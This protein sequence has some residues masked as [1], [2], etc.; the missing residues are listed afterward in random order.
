MGTG[1]R[2]DRALLEHVMSVV[3]RCGMTIEETLRLPNRDAVSRD[4]PG[5]LAAR[6]RQLLEHTFPDGLYSHQTEAIDGALDGRDICLATNTASGKTLVF[7]TAA[8]NLLLQDRSARVL[9]L[10][11]ARALIQDQRQKWER[12]LVPLGLTFSHIDGG[13]PIADR[14][15]RL[16]SQVVLMTPDVLHAWMMSHLGDDQVRHFLAHVRLLILDELHVYEG[17]F[18]SNMAYLLRRL[19]AVTRRPQIICS[20]ATL[21]KPESFVAQLTGRAVTTLGPSDDGSP[22]PPKDIVLL[23]GRADTFEATVDL[24]CSLG[25][26]HL[27]RFLAFADSRKAVERIVAATYRDHRGVARP[28][29]LEDTGEGLEPQGDEDV[30]DEEIGLPTPTL[31]GQAILPYRAGYETDDRLAVQQA[32]TNGDLVGV[33]STSALELG[34]DI[35]DIDVVVLLDVPPTLKSFWQRLGRAGRRNPAVCLIFD[36]RGRLPKLG[37]ELAAYLE[38]PIEPN[39]LYLDNRYIQYANV[40]CAAAEI[41]GDHIPEPFNSLPSSFIEFLQNEIHPQELV[42]ADLYQL[43]QRGQND[44]HHEFALRGAVEQSFRIRD[45]AGKLGDVTLAQA[46]RE[47]YPGAVYLYMARPHRIRG[48]QYRTG[49][50][51]AAY[52]PMYTTRPITQ[53]TVFPR[54]DGGILTYLKSASGFAIEA[55]MQVS[56]RVTGFTEQRG[57]TR[58]M[59]L[60]GPGSPYSQR[61]LYRFFETTGVCWLLGQGSQLSEVALDAILQTFAAEFGIQERDLGYGYFHSNVRPDGPGPVRGTCIYDTTQGS[62]RLTQLLAGHFKEVVRSTLTAVRDGALGAPEDELAALLA[63]AED[64]EPVAVSSG[65]AIEP[66]GADWATVIAP[67]EVGMFISAESTQEVRVLD[68]KYTPRG[69]MYR[70]EHPD[71]TVTWMVPANE[72]QPIYCTTRLVRVNLVT[73]DVEDL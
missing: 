12:T 69:L 19:D 73:G 51:T 26:A 64:L 66:A 72:L 62:L 55:E 47:A 44:P 25:D 48:W 35:G 40:L 70:L 45:H 38:R 61:Q 5:R 54:F 39:W 53:T 18:G 27:G 14:T 3:G 68:Y 67:G 8:A 37:L 2:D 16:A 23:G 24:L 59:H 49:V 50:I 7:M 60:Y 43:K 11:P 29:P 1:T 42:P 71:P 36:P 30:D 52:T 46:L 34:L 57:L 31:P 13:V 63:G 65:R 6:L 41:R 33:V 10:Y 56:E 32:L 9:A 21:G 15:E 4:I 28:E 58:S 20:T 17:A 22:L